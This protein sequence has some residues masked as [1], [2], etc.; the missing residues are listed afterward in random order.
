M[1]NQ[2]DLL[3]DNLE[4]PSTKEEINKVCCE[5]CYTAK[6]KKCTCKC[7]GAYHGLGR[8]TMPNDGSTSEDFYLSGEEAKPFLDQ[9][10][11]KECRWCGAD[12]SHE[13]VQAYGPHSGGWNVKGYDEPLWLFIRCP[14][15]KYDWSL[16]KLGVARDNV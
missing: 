7:N 8:H 4:L 12:L 15:C 5:A 2:T 9:I 1:L 14:K 16:W 13:L 10:E 11:R 6:E 3:G